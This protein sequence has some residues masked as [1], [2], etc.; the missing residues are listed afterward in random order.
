[1]PPRPVKIWLYRIVHIADLPAVLERGLYP[2][3]HPDWQPPTK[4][5]GSKDLAENRRVY[6][7]DPP[8]TGTIGDHV[9][10]Y[11]GPHS[12]MLYR[13]MTGHNVAEA[14]PQRE[15]IYLLVSFEAV[16]EAGLPYIIADGHANHRLI[17]RLFDSPEGFAHVDWDVVGDRWWRNSEEDRDRERRKQAEF[18]VR[19]HIPPA[20]VDAI[21][22]YDHERSVEVAELVRKFGLG[23]RVKVDTEHKLYYP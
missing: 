18:L 15:I 5:L 13:I 3:T 20:L 21:G 10:F 8:A 23:A 22:V 11:L 4:R 9:A 2:C 17:T 1:M 12:P 7:L 14:F 19:G 16:Q 6:T